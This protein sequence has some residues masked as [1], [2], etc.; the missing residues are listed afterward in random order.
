MNKDR[1][2]RLAEVGNIIDDA[3]TEIQDIVDEEQDAFDGLPD[4][5]QDSERGALMESAIGDMEDLIM[6]LDNFISELNKVVETYS[7][8]KKKQ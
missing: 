5:F 2:D 3:M 7:P 4:S 8:K 6:T 1:R